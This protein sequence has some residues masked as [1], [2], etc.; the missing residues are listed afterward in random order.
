MHV[1]RNGVG[2]VE[3]TVRIR[4]HGDRR[5]K[6]VVQLYVGSEDPR[7]PPLELRAFDPVELDAGAEAHLTFTLGERAF[8]QWDSEVGRFAPI[9]GTH[10][11]AVG[12]SSRNLPLRTSVTFAPEAATL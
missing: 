7:R 2:E 1:D 4:N 3:V 10:E 9:P 5:G 11:I 6:E 12:S 8:S